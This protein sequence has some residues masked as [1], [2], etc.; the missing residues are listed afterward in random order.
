MLTSAPASPPAGLPGGASLGRCAVIGVL[1]VTSD[2][3]SDGGRYLDE[4]TALAHAEQMYADG[5]DIIDV[6]GE[7]T[8][9]GAAR[10]ASGDEA[11]RVVPVL[12]TLAARGIPT[13]VDTMRADVARA[14]LDAGCTAINDVSGGL[15]DP[16]M[17]PVAAAYDVPVILMHWRAHSATMRDFATYEDVV[18]D[19]RR[20]LSARVDAALAAGVKPERIAIDPGLGF[21][22]TAEHNWQLLRRLD[23]LLELGYPVLVAASRKSFLGSLLAAPDGTPRPPDQREDAT[24]AISMMSAMVG[25]W[26]VRVHKVRPSMD[27]VRVAAAWAGR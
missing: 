8:R 2:S 18:Q 5:A 23:A 25:A 7:S 19:V 20:E 3:F 12:K 27:A 1:N 6:G 17:L 11:R 21:A 15:A 10:V 26:A 4:S 13:T 24:A 16:D 14:A 22:K 9:P